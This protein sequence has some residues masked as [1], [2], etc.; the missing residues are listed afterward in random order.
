[1]ADAPAAAP[2]K[3]L[4]GQKA[5]PV[6]PDVSDVRADINNLNTRIRLSE[7]R[8]ND[9]RK[10][11]QFLEQSQIEFQKKALGEIK[12]VQSDITA[13]K[14]DLSE[15]KSRLVLLIKELQLTAKQSDIQ[16]LQKYMDM[17]QPVKWVQVDQVQRI[18]RE[19]LE[20]MAKEE[21]SGKSK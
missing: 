7:E 8:F 20:K 4:F 2:P 21:E 17:W 13:L 11:L 10:K 16:V 6:Q 5:P 19:E 12:M 15:T 18:V 1:M 9:Q 3:G 14:R